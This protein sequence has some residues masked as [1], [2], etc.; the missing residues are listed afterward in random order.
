MEN[1]ITILA[2]LGVVIVGLS[3]AICGMYCLDRAVDQGDISP[4]KKPAQ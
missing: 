2:V 3:I 1:L 4:D